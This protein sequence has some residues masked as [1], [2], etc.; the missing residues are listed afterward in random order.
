MESEKKDY[1]EILEVNIKASKETISKVF[2]M[3]I[4]KNHPDLFQG[5][6]K[7]AAEEK[8]M[9]LNEAYEVLSDEKKREAYDKTLNAEKNEQINFLKEQIQLLKEE[10]LKKQ[11]ILQQIREEYALYD[12]ERK[13]M[14]YNKV[15]EHQNDIENTSN[16]SNIN[17]ESHY[18]N[19]NETEDKG[20]THQDN[21]YDLKV[22]L[23][24]ILGAILLMVF[25][26]FTVGEVI[27]KNLLK[28]VFIEIFI[29]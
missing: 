11:S 24:K 12:Q 7:K 29:K 25:A 28:D 21:F 8:T 16:I 4:K 19:E 27:G 26:L 17:R 5:E 13:N 10:L 14:L 23:L 22:F 1:Y 6:E 3:Q 20:I 15:R 18:N 2:K 9:L